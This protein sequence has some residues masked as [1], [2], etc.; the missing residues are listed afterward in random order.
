[1]PCWEVTWVVVNVDI[2]DRFGRLVCLLGAGV[3]GW[4]ADEAAGGAGGERSLEVAGHAGA[5]SGTADSVGTG[6]AGGTTTHHP[7]LT[8]ACK[9]DRFLGGTIF[10]WEGKGGVS[11]HL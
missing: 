6:P 1:M 11:S 8:A 2:V 5:P 10:C 7:G 4:A 9:H 3:A